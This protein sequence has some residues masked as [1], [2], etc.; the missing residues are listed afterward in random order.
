MPDAE[1]KGVT[2]KCY[3]RVI[4]DKFLKPII[5]LRVDDKNGV[6]ILDRGLSI[7]RMWSISLGL[8]RKWL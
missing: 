7:L 3:F 6:I 1:Q 8:E 2:S 4:W 5:C